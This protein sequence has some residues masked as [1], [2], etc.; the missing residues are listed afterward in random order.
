M[1]FKGARRKT[2]GPPPIFWRPSAREQ[3]ARVRCRASCR[4]R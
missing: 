4:R 1:R 3:R 2:A